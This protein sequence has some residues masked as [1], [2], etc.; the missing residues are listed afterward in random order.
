MSITLASYVETAAIDYNTNVVNANH[1]TGKN[2]LGVRKA[3]LHK[4]INII[5]GRQYR[6]TVRMGWNNGLANE[7]Q[8]NTAVASA[9]V[10]MYGGVDFSFKGKKTTTM[11]DVTDILFGDEVT[12]MVKD[13][14]LAAAFGILYKWGYYLMIEGCT[15]TWAEDA[16]AKFIADNGF[17][18][19]LG[20]TCKESKHISHHG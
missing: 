3:W 19:I 1:A 15:L 6:D 13:G 14:N 11:K 9:G 7:M 2:T 4:V 12:K 10:G 18:V 5:F 20:D 16:T 8:T 17:Q